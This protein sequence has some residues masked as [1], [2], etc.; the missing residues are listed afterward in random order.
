MDDGAPGGR[1]PC[2]AARLGRRAAGLPGV[3]LAGAVQGPA[4]HTGCAEGRLA[5]ALTSPSTKGGGVFGARP[6]LV[7]ASAAFSWRVA[8]AGPAAATSRRS[9]ATARMVVMSLGRRLGPWAGGKGKLRTLRWTKCGTE[10]P[11]LS[12]AASPGS[13]GQRRH[14]GAVQRATE[15]SRGRATTLGWGDSPGAFAWGLGGSGGG[16]A[17]GWC[18]VEA[19]SVVEGR[20]VTPSLRPRSGACTASGPA[21]ARPKS[22]TRPSPLGISSPDG[23]SGMDA[24][25]SGRPDTWS[26][27]AGRRGAAADFRR[28]RH[29]GFLWKPPRQAGRQASG[30]AHWAQCS[31]KQC[32]HMHRQPNWRP[33]SCSTRRRIRRR[34]RRRLSRPGRSGSWADGRCNLHRGNR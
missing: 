3:E 33:G 19:R 21:E 1:K 4:N 8:A 5:E 7:A 12:P 32:L 10:P 27:P 14:T 11:L 13:R 24:A 6:G 22:R 31:V 15:R 18:A 29:R 30:P 2:A 26:C 16:R 9:R 23:A 34:R 17:C 25:R 28:C 20:A